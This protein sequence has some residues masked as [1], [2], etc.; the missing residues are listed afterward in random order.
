MQ[1]ARQ[2]I[3]NLN[4]LELSK[5]ITQETKHLIYRTIIQNIVLYAVKTWETLQRE[6][7]KLVAVESS[8]EA[9]ECQ[10]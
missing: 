1:Y 2:V 4:S 9:R 5:Q 3:N 10:D 6:S 7:Q 8:G